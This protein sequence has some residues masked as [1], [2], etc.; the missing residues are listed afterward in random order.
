MTL[1]IFTAVL[2]LFGG[3]IVTGIN[4]IWWAIALLII[5]LIGDVMMLAAGM[6]IIALVEVDA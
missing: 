4:H 3:V 2:A 1:R 5:G 6:S